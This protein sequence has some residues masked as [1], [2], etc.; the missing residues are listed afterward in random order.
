MITLIGTGHVFNISEPILEIFDEKKPEIICVELDKERCQGLLLKQSDKEGYKKKMD[1]TSSIYKLLAR[2]Q[3][4]MAEEYGVIAGQEMLT[5]INYAQTHQIPLALI[6][7]NA[8]ELFN[9][10][11]KEMKISEKLRLLIS[12]IAGFFVSKKRVEKELSR[13]EKNFD[14]YLNDVG[15]KFPTIKKVLIDDRNNFM[16]KKIINAKEQYENIIAVL[17]DGHIPGISKILEDEKISFETVRLK[18]LRKKSE[19]KITDSSSASFSIE[20]K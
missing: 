10:M 13:I 19:N 6:D 2:F 3:D 1:N 5:A 9:K 18:D 7:M 8:K 14:S 17:G 20:Y 11:F 16:A 12:G 4:N 15:D